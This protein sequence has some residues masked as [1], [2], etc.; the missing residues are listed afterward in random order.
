MCAGWNIWCTE[1]C[2]FQSS[3]LARR[4]CSLVS[5]HFEIGVPDH[6][7]VEWNA[8][9]EAGPA[10]EVLVGK[11]ENLLATLERPGGNRAGVGRGAHDAAVRAAESLEIGSRIDVGHR[12]DFL[13]GVQDLAE[14]TPA[15][16]DLGQVGHVRHR[17][18]RC[19]VRQD[20]RLLRLRHDV[21][22]FG[23]EMHTA[24]HDV[25]GIGL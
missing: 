9:L 24:E 12:R 16:F 2:P 11:E 23:H 17:A 8:H 25:A 4:I 21:G 18:A 13:L 19:Q 1:Q 6:H 10:P 3:S 22:D 7:L 20:R 5:P 14:F 15:A